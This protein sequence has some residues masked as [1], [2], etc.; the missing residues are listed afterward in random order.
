M[1]KLAQSPR[2]SLHWQRP[3]GRS[4]P[5]LTETAIERV[6]EAFASRKGPLYQEITRD[7]P[8]FV[9][10]E[11]VP[12]QRAFRSD[13]APNLCALLVTLLATSSLQT[14]FVARPVNGNW[15]R[16][17]WRD[18][19]GYAYGELVPGERSLRRTERHARELVALGFVTIRQLRRKTAE[20][21]ESLV[22]VKHLGLKLWR[23]LGMEKAI[24]AA[25][26]RIKAEAAEARAKG[27][28]LTVIA[29]IQDVL[30]RSRK[31]ASAPTPPP[32]PAESPPAKPPPTDE[33]RARILAQMEETA[34]LLGLAKR[35]G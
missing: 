28:G 10:G 13:A 32:T 16:R 30:K 9:G 5:Q 34:K 26:Q 4:W 21:Y 22:A 2:R 6:T 24:L 15:E 23:L 8:R 18:L 12:R 7:I 35:G 1:S 3:K 25:G 29:G 11:L 27:R 31:K 20:G 19:D 14:G 17:E 33:Q